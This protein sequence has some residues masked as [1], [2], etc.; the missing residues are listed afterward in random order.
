MLCGIS[1]NPIKPNQNPRKAK[2]TI[3]K[4]KRKK[5]KG[6][7]T[8]DNNK[9]NSFLIFCCCCFCWRAREKF[10]FP[11]TTTT[12][13][14]EGKNSV[15]CFWGWLIRQAKQYF[16]PKGYAKSEITRFERV[17]RAEW[18]KLPQSVQKSLKSH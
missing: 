1:E 5:E 2:K 7:P 11:T 3:V 17:L 12:T 8:K 9:K 4:G 15:F 16:T 18:Y 6:K 10:R 14:R 13:T